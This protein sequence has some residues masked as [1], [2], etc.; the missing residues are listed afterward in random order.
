[1]T[2]H[3]TDPAH[4][5]PAPEEVSAATEAEPKRKR[6]ALVA[7]KGS[8][9]MVYPV[10]MMASTAAALGWEVGIFCTFYGLDIVNKK[11]NK[12]LQVAAVG[13]PASPPP[14]KGLPVK[15]PPLLGVLPGAQAAATTFMK[16]WMR[17]SNMPEFQ[18][19]MENLRMAEGRQGR[20][21]DNPGQ[22]A[23]EGLAETM[24]VMSV[25]PEDMIDGV[26]CLGATAFLDY[27]ADA[28]VCLFV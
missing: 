7:S 23:M 19:L 28:D 26:S 24:G 27:A 17:D 22:Q 6:L 12:H 13:N 21:G 15:V 14:F 16:K 9:D 11:R 8:L 3:A 5:D 1:M 2:L 25:D 10:L 4:M 20:N 18:E